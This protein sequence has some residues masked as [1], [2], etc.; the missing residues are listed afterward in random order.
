MKFTTIHLQFTTMYLKFTTIHLQF[1]TVHLQFCT[2]QLKFT[3]IKLKFCNIQ[4][5]F[6]TIHLQF[7]TMYLRFTTIYLQ[8]R[9]VHLQ[10]ST[11]QL[12]IIS[13]TKF[14]I[15]IGSPR[16]YLSHNRRAIMWV[17]NYRCLIWTFSK[18][19]PV[20]GYPH[21]FHVNH[22]RFNGFLSNVF[23]SFQRLG[24]EVLRRH[25]NSRNLL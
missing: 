6:T 12:L 15:M 14:L 16:A 10:F 5:K 1:S 23:Y 8:F 7:T 22:T 4:L 19:T 2:I 18:R 17:S 25:F 21:D 13:I 11:I 9:T 20:I 24:K 3:S